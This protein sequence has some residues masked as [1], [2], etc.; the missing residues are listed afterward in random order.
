M[1]VAEVVQPHRRQAGVPHGLLKREREQ[2][3]DHRLAVRLPEHQVVPVVVV[4][5][6]QLLLRL[7]LAMGTQ[8]RDG[9]TVQVDRAPARAS[10]SAGRTSARNVARA[11]SAP[12]QVG[13]SRDRGPSTSDREA[14]PSAYR[15]SRPG[16]TPLASGAP[17]RSARTSAPGRGRETSGPFAPE[18]RRPWPSA[19]SPLRS[20]CF[21]AP[22]APLRR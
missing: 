8:H 16:G 3:R 10:S 2:M 17:G 14:P 6:S 18:L 20:G 22:A 7:P 15:W 4:T 13:P 5:D 12:P 11:A 21:R 1:G 19:A 9:L